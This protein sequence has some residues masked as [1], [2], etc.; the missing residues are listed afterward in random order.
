MIGAIIGDV[1][2]SRFEFNNTDK[3]DF[4]FMTGSCNYT[5]D[6]VMTCAVALALLRCGGDYSDLDEKAIDAM[7]ELGK[8][9]PHAGYGG[10]FFNWVLGSDRKPYNS[11]GNGSAM[12]VSAVG[13]VAKTIDEAKELSYKVTAVT[14][15]H[16]KGIKGA[17][18]MAVCMVLARQG[19]TKEEIKEY[20]RE[21]YGYD[22]DKTV[23]KWREEIGGRHGYEICQV[24]LPE[25]LS[26]F[27]ESVGF[28]DCIRNC[29][30]IGGDSDTLAAIAG[31]I[32]EAYYGVPEKWKKKVLEYLPDDLLEITKEFEARF[33]FNDRS[34]K[35]KARLDFC[36]KYIP[37]LRMVEDD[38]DL[39]HACSVHSVYQKDT[40]HP[41]LIRYLYDEF[42]R[43]AYRVDMVI[44]NYRSLVEEIRAVKSVERMTEDEMRALD[45]EHLLAC[46]AWHFRADHF[47]EGSLISESIAEGHMLRMLEIY[48]E[49]IGALKE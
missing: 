29:I 5:D 45:A 31:A 30:S 42:M 23:D 21:N 39:K 4:E 20:V 3:K 7:K 37:V 27:F 41:A 32:A 9:H 17:E 33:G 1:V 6:T 10:M 26:C 49:K 2:G 47:C 46:I 25:A 43:E 28:E 18:C 19:K 36:R 35:D 48:T 16:P 34:E 38:D 14:H 8:A 40:E 44:K 15:N 12:R 11:Y 13:N 22:V 24:S